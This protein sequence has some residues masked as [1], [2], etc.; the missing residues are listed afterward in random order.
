V[1]IRFL[2]DADL[3]PE[4]VYGLRRRAPAINFILSQGPIPEATRDPN[5]LAVARNLGRVLVSHDR[6]TMPKHFYAFLEHS[7][8]PGLILLSQTYPLRD[9]I[10]QLFYIWLFSDPGELRNRIT[11]LPL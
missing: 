6:R 3:R 9:A 8:S 11:Y 2:A 4:I 7:E 1:T 5:V 10:E